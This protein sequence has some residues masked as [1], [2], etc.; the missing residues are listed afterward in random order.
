[1]D[2]LAAGFLPPMAFLDI[3]RDLAFFGILI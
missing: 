3:L 1:M 2:F